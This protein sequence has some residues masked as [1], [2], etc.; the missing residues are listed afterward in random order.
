MAQIINPMAQVTGLSNSGT[1]DATG[2][3]NQDVDLTSYGVPTNASAVLL[4]LRLAGA[5]WYGAR[6][7]ADDTAKSEFQGDGPADGVST[8]IVPCS[9][10]TV[11]LYLEDA[12]ND[13]WYVAGYWE[14][15]AIEWLA[16]GSETTD[17]TTG[18]G[19]YTWDY[20]ARRAGAK[21]I[22]IVN[23][24][25]RTEDMSGFSIATATSPSAYSRQLDRNSNAASDVLQYVIPLDSGEAAYI[26]TA[27]AGTRTFN[28]VGY[29]LQDISFL[30]DDNGGPAEAPTTT[31]NVWTAGGYDFGAQAGIGCLAQDNG[32]T[33]GYWAAADT[34][35]PIGGTAS[36]RSTP[37]MHM[38]SVK[39]D[40][41]FN[42][43][44]ETGTPSHDILWFMG[45]SPDIT[46]VSS[47]NVVGSTENPWS[48]VG[49]GFGTD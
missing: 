12:T 28:I 27:D 37:G 40:G 42:Y 16:A 10:G 23:T 13:K 14:A 34:S 3:W 18:S 38:F 1:T 2:T 29:V 44:M 48:I 35:D 43:S 46:S 11:D 47:D 9:N 19:T 17:Q 6:N 26:S 36:V 22:I 30:Y 21:G 39:S 4:Y 15:G 24:E 5:R 8:F 49:T 32:L 20:T 41:T 7:P 33:Q 25:D 45:P 31:G